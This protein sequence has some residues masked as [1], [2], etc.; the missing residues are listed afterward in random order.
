[1]VAILRTVNWVEQVGQMSLFCRP[2]RSAIS[3]NKIKFNTTKMEVS[4]ICNGNANNFFQSHKIYV[5]QA[6]ILFNQT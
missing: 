1:M 3:K 5:K 6:I 2:S 4:L